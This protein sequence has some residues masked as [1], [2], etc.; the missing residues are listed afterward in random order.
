MIQKPAQKLSRFRNY[1]LLR[2]TKLTGPRTPNGTSNWLGLFTRV[3]WYQ[4]S[5][6]HGTSNWLGLSTR[7][8]WHQN[9]HPHGKSNWYWMSIQE[10]RYQNLHPHGISNRCWLSIHT[11]MELEIDL[12]SVHTG[13]SISVDVETIAIQKLSRFT[14]YHGSQIISRFRN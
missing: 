7:I 11:P 3:I 1:F 12:W 8:R 13:K 5:H 6:P 10:R 9:S 2:F 4:H 14:N